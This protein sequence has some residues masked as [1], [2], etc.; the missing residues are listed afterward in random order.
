MSKS[1]KINQKR[2]SLVQL[3]AD[4]RIVARGYQVITTKTVWFDRHRLN[5]D[6]DCCQSSQ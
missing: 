4:G 3:N 2:L 1:V 6:A 5:I